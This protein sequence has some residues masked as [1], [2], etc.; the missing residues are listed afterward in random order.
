MSRHG[1]DAKY[2]TNIFLKTKQKGHMAADGMIK[3]KLDYKWSVMVEHKL[4][5]TDRLL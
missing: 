5:P 4:R 1:R 2:M 3:V